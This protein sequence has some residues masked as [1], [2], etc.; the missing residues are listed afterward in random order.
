MSLSKRQLL[1][2]LAELDR[3]LDHEL[4]VV[5]AGGTAMTLY[6][7]KPSTIDVDFTIPAEYLSEFHKVLDLTPH[8][9]KVDTWSDGMVFSQDLPGDYLEKSKPVRTKMKN[10][11]LRVLDPLDI[12][13]TKIG[14]LNEKD[15][16]DIMTC[17][18]KSHITKTQIINRAKQV[19]YTGREENYKINLNHVTK[20]FF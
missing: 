19:V 8:G 6:N 7:F 13:V 20:K 18:R 4:T 3:E 17:I 1:D 2:F 14:R 9:F 16:E 11:R 10:I 5:A 15:K 12:I